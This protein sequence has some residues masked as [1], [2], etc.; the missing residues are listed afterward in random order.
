MNVTPRLESA[1]RTAAI[2]HSTQLRKGSK[3]PYITHPFGVMCI[4]QTVTEDEDILIACLFHDILEDV[5]ENYSRQ[6]M[7]KDY[8]DRV[9]SIVD[10]VT[11]DDTIKDWQGRADAY[12]SHLKNSASDESVIVSCA[13]KVHNLMTIL[14]DYKVVGD[15]LW[16]RFNAVK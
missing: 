10:G 7:I 2:A 5:P 16:T 9:V 13:D 12:L 3:T 11:K 6:Q 8:G 14:E 1:I 15:V 4:A